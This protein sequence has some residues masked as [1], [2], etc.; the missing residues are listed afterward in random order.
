[1]GGIVYLVGAGPGD[2]DLIT[3]KG[4][5]CIK[6]A[7]VIV[8]DRL[9]NPILLEERAD[10]C[11]LIYVGKSPKHHIKT[12][13]EINE[14]LFQEAKAG[15]KVVR[16]KGWRSLC[17]GMRGEEGEYLYNKNI[18]FEV[19]PGITSAIGGL[20]YGGIPITHRGLA[21]SFHVITG[22]LKMNMKN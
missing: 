12:Q 3:L 20:A 2:P 21:R 11:K 13:D 17:F 4:I 16:L 5:Q 14:I 9:A 6:S 22:H 15:N 10:N 8:Y 18:P 19:V 7:D 1:M